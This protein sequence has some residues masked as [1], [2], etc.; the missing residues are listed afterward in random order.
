M[1]DV[2]LDLMMLPSYDVRLLVLADV[3]SY[4]EGFNVMSPTLAVTVPGYSKK[5]I[6]F[7]KGLINVLNSK[8]LQ[9]PCSGDC[10]LTSLPD[11]IYTFEYAIFPAYKYN[12]T[13]TFFRVDKIFEKYDE[14]FLRSEILECDMKTKRTKKLLL[15]EAEEYIQGAIAAASKCANHQATEYYK[16][17]DKIL[18]SIN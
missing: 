3:S 14:K 11:G 7:Q 5:Q 15:E 2:S 6:P 8:V 9:I 10:P 1:A 16:K 18:N 4:P 12:I 13:K 17:A